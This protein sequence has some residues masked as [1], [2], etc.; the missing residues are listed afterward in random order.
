MLNRHRAL[1]AII[2][3]STLLLASGAHAQD[4]APPTSTTPATPTSGLVAPKLTKNVDPTY[5]PAKLAAGERAKV[6]LLLT[7]DA[8]GHV[9]DA[10]VTTSAGAEFDGS[11]LLA[12]RELGFEGALRDG[13][14][15][16][17]KIPFVFTFDFKDE[18]PPATSDAPATTP[19][20]PA[21]PAAPVDPLA[22]AAVTDIDVK[23]ERASREVTRRAI[24][25]A[26][27]LRIP[28][29][30]GDALRSIENLPG[31]A[32]PPGLSGL[33]IVR[34]SAPQDT[35]VFVDGTT[36]PIA[37]H[38]GGL[39]SVVPSEMLE[40]IDF[41]PGNFSAQYGRAMGGV[42]DIG[43]RSPRKDGIHGLAQ[44]DLLDARVLAEAPLG[45]STRVMVAGRRSWVDA[46]IGPVMEKTGAA[47]STAPRYY[48]YQA[49]IEHDFS[50]RTTGRVLLFGSDDR[51]AINA[52]NPSA[53]D[54]AIGGDISSTTT[55]WRLQAR[56]DSRIGNDV[57]W[58]NTASIGQ[59]MLHGTVGGNFWN[60]TELPIDVRSDL[61]A[62]LTPQV[63][64]IGG[65]DIQTVHYDL[66]TKFPPFV[67][68][69]RAPGPLFAQ[70]PDRLDANA[71]TVRPGAYVMLDVSPVP[72]LKILP[73]IRVDYAHPSDAWTVDPRLA[74]RWDVA[75]THRTTLK[76][77]IGAF[78]QPPQPQEIIA[79]VGTPGVGPS[80]AMHYS[81]GVEQE[82]SRNVELSVEGFYKDLDHVVEQQS[83][84][85]SASGVAY[86]NTGS[87]RVYGAEFLLRY[88][89]DSH[90]FGWI[91]YTLSKSDRRETDEV[92]W[93]PYQYDQRHILTA[94]G[95]Y[96]LGRGWELGA[97]W[98]YTSGDRYTP[99][100]GGVADFD[101]GAYSPVQSTKLYSA[102]SPAFH[103]LDVRVEKTWT[104]PS[105]KLSAYL[106][107]QN[108]YNRP[109]A[110]GAAYNY[111]YS[112][113]DVV[114][115]LPI[116]PIIGLRGEL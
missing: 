39:T 44:V 99:F 49:Q 42:I 24:T 54:P 82:L 74:V 93:H 25:G 52:S 71:S 36:I 19:S 72:A 15:I 95:S 61:S 48:D 79:P 69:S 97:R 34:G 89:P 94:L 112:R 7:I 90:F 85:S 101:A 73:G 108:V 29:T 92:A 111:N 76:A 80:R 65:V 50:A 26:E 31:V 14:P 103:Q 5:P 33:L 51:L 12:A 68:P 3:G 2:A 1:A 47:I 113:T 17:A 83:A 110:E 84:S 9:T 59:D 104:F 87:G 41:Y 13:K 21:T 56:L 115:G 78:H 55:F 75:S 58:I 22:G 88:K 105:W 16:A 30:R 53:A 63:T 67:D 18:P 114:P 116:L 32:R 57:R 106:D 109:N 35:Q 96:Q 20:A 102:S 6:V 45:D 38:F 4:S 8:T 27:I 86:A 10:A 81:V 37:Y 43:I 91:A 11:A 46:W 62:R 77:G 28:G 66:S 100:V 70:Q 23:G 107:V 64:V 60:V 40:R 98:R